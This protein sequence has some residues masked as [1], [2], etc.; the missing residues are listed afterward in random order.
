MY[1]KFKIKFLDNSRLNLGIFNDVFP[2][3]FL[4][5]FNGS[6]G[7]SKREVLKIFNMN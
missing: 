7:H 4:L 6:D 3:N 1:A 5:K 2:H